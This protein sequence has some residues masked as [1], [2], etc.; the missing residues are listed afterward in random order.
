MKNLNIPQYE[1]HLFNTDN[2]VDP[3]LIA[4]EK[5][6]NHQSVQLIKCHCE[7][8]NNT[9]PFSNI[10]HTEIEMELKKLEC[11]ESS[12]NSDIPT[13]VIKD[14]VDIFTPISR[15]EFNKSLELG[16]FQSEMKLVDVKTSF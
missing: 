10:T 12:Q 15:Q 3:I 5:C 13:K 9:F 14:N 16:K 2:I 7:D 6:K 4:K 11:S 8:K 1:D